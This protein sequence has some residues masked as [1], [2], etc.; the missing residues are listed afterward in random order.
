MIFQLFRRTPGEHTIATL[1]GTIV[2]QARAPAFYQIYGVPD[3]VNGRFEM[4]VLHAVVL[5]NRLN[6]GEGTLRSLGQA[7]FDMFCSDMDGNLRE[8]GVG[9][10]ARLKGVTADVRDPRM[11]SVLRD[12][13]AVCAQ[14]GVTVMCSTGRS[15]TLDE[16]LTSIDLLWKIGIKVIWVSNP[17]HIVFKAYRTIMDRVR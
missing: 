15:D 7:I 12:A 5:L 1:Y 14:K 10:L 11:A 3:T 16:I 2:A 17:S 9:D 8:M 4:I 13:V 6:A